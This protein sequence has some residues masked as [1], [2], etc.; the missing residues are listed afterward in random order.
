MHKTIQRAPRLATIL[1][2]LAA[3]LVVALGILTAS[4]DAHRTIDAWRAEQ[5][6]YNTWNSHCGNGAS[7]TCVDRNVYDHA[8]ATGYHSWDVEYHWVERGAY[9]AGTLRTCGIGV[10]VEHDWVAEILRPEHCW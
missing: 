5:I 6:V 2:I 8:V 7:W 3:S 1:P 9:G 10:R 4:A